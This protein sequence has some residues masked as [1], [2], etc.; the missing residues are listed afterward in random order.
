VVRVTKIEVP[1]SGCSTDPCYH[2]PYCT[3][4]LSLRAEVIRLRQ[5]REMAQAELARLRLMLSR[6][7]EDI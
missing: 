5:E 1:C 3:E 2:W 7:T 6:M 4:L